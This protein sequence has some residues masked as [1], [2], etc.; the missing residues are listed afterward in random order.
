MK[1]AWSHSLPSDFSSGAWGA[2]S[3][4]HVGLLSAVQ[5]VLYILNANGASSFLVSFF[6]GRIYGQNDVGNHGIET[7]PEKNA[8]YYSVN[9]NGKKRW[10]A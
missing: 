10:H 1:Q 2:G 4:S 9:T 3:H 6:K 8:R 5:D 7:V